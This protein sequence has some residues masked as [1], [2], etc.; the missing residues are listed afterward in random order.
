M[1]NDPKI[2]AQFDAISEQFRNALQPYVGHYNVTAE[3]LESVRHSLQSCL[4]PSVSDRS[5]NDWFV[6]GHDPEDRNKINISLKEQAFAAGEIPMWVLQYMWAMNP[7][8]EIF[9]AFYEALMQRFNLSE[10]KIH[11]FPE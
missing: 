4:E 7:H 3:T 6:I 5:F 10:V 1:I 8:F 2:Q 11:N 9:D